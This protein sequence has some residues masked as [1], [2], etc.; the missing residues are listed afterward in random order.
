VTQPAGE[1]VPTRSAARYVALAR[2][3]ETRT[4]NPDDEMRHASRNREVQKLVRVDDNFAREIIRRFQANEAG[5]ELLL[6]RAHS[7]LI[8]SIIRK[9]G[10]GS[11][12]DFEDWMQ[13]GKLA[14]LEACA[15]F[16]LTRVERS[17]IAY[18]YSYI[19]GYLIREICNVGSI[20]RIPRSQYQA[21]ATHAAYKYKLNRPHVWLFSE[22][23]D[24]MRWDLEDAFEDT[25]RDEQPTADETISEQEIE[26]A[27]PLLVAYLLGKLEPRLEEIMVERF[28]RG[29]TLQDIAEG[30][31]VSRERVRQLEVMAFTG[32]RR[33]VAYLGAN[34][35][36][37][38]DFGSWVASA[39]VALRAHVAKEDEEENRDLV[40]TPPRRKVSVPFMKVEAAFCASVDEHFEKHGR[41]R[42]VM[43][44]D[45]TPSVLLCQTLERVAGVKKRR[46][47]IW[48]R[49]ASAYRL[50]LKCGIC[51][52]L[53]AYEGQPLT[54]TVRTEP[55]PM[56]AK[57]PPPAPVARPAPK[58]VVVPDVPAEPFTPFLRAEDIAVRYGIAE[59]GIEKR[60]KRAKVR[61]RALYW[62]CGTTHPLWHEEQIAAIRVALSSV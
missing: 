1:D 36:A 14:M 34:V 37:T 61:P 56:P 62:K 13:T 59:F 52:R 30:M 31:G 35:T 22:M 57:V 15:R 2:L 19:K 23:A 21:T 10:R 44:T 16:D 48:M 25:L 5:S 28:F 58:P 51:E 24:H 8:T 6:I 3:W 40:P 27:T 20:V 50:V 38:H 53:F 4:G 11:P 54:E 60:L 47:G 12:A 29:K 46:R 49:A 17:P 41:L 55:P 18:L 26:D 45:R 39:I 9:Y 43:Q 7:G 33:H 42:L 32:L